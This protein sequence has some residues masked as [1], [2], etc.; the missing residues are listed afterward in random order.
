VIN[1]LIKIRSYGISSAKRIKILKTPLKIPSVS[2]M[3]ISVF[4]RVIEASRSHKRR[5]PAE[6]AP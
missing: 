2:N 1:D 3:G 4:R 5:C 6:G